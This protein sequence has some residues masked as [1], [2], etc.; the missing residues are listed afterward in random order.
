MQGWA[1][2]PKRF[3]RLVTERRPIWPPEPKASGSNPLWR[4]DYGEASLPVFRAYGGGSRVEEFASRGRGTRRNWAREDIGRGRE[5]GIAAEMQGRASARR[6][7][8]GEEGTKE[9]GKG[10]SVGGESGAKQ[11][12]P[13]RSH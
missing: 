1:R 9:G 11:A 6:E 4:T 8:V 12:R 10:G 3:H 13:Q 2:H 7:G 5:A